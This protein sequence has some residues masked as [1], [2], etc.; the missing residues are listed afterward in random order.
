M[1]CRPSSE[2]FDFPFTGF[3]FDVSE[4]DIV[5]I[6][7]SLSP[8][9]P[10]DG[11]L[12]SSSGSTAQLLMPSD[13]AGPARQV[14]PPDAENRTWEGACAQSHAPDAINGAIRVLCDLWCKAASHRASICHRRVLASPSRSHTCNTRVFSAHESKRKHTKTRLE[15]TKVC[16]L[17]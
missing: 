4:G 3:C 15:H 14:Q 16:A 5:S 2:R 12:V 8:G 10:F 6:Y 7:I 11:R 17:P 1:R 13:F 9:L